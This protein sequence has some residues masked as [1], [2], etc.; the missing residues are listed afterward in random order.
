[1]I[2]LGTAVTLPINA[3]KTIH[4]HPLNECMYERANECRS[5]EMQKNEDIAKCSLR[6]SY[7]L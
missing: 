6:Q 1:M 2:G 7:V 3:T 4:F 5:K